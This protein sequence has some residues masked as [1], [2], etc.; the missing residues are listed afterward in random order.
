M[1]LLQVEDG[2]RSNIMEG[3]CGIDRISSREQPTSGGPP[4]LWL[5]ELLTTHHRKT[6]LVTKHRNWTLALVNAVMNLRVP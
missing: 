5:G 2:G 1:A 3:S 6:Y 4:N